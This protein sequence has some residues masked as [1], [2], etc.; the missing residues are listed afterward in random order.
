M[1]QK[2]RSIIKLSFI[3]DIRYVKICKDIKYSQYLNKSYD[4]NR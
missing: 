3:T 2:S 4:F 1:N